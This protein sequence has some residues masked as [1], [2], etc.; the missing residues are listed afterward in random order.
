MAQVASESLGIP[1][2]QITVKLGDS[3]LPEG[4]NSGGSQTSAS[5]GPAIRAAA[6][7]ARNKVLRLCDGDGSSPLHRVQEDGVA[8]RDGR[9]YRIGDES[10]G[11][12]YAQILRRHNLRMVEEEV[13]TDV[14]TRE[15]GNQKKKDEKKSNAETKKDEQVDRSKYGFHSFGAVFAKVRVDPDLGIV[16]VTD[17]AGVMDIGKV[18]N[19]KMAKNQIMGGMLFALGMALMEGTIYDPNNGRVVTRDLASYLVPVHADAPHFDIRFIDKPDPYISP[20]GSRGIGEIGITGTAAA[21]ANAVYHAT[22]K[23]VRELPIT[24]DKLI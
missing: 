2:E 19:L 22:G 7:G 11:E 23:R 14:S 9:I 20:V 21:I 5:I 10:A 24:P 6:I 16:R 1:V 8:A 4:P 17:C 18:L 15:G 13:K 3:R 12:S